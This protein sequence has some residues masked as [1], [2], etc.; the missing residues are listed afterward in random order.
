MNHEL[1]VCIVIVVQSWLVLTQDEIG[2]KA[3]H[4]VKESSKLVNFASK[5]NVWARVLVQIQL[6]LMNMLLKSLT[7]LSQFAYL[8]SKLENVEE[9]LGL[10]ELLL[11]GN[12]VLKI[13]KESLHARESVLSEILRGWFILLDTFQ[14]FDSQVGLL[15][16]FI[17]DGCE[18]VILLLNFLDNFLFNAFLLH[19]S[20]IHGA[21]VLERSVGLL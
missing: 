13:C 16:L 1:F 14:V 12:P 5:H 7:L 17:N 20:V 15:T 2:L 3:D 8:V 11:F 18:F 19:N 4:I 9:F 6:M 10:S 21:A